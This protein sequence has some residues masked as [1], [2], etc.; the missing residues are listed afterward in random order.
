MKLK[1]DNNYFIILFF[2]LYF[3]TGI[4][5]VGDYSVT[6]D[7][8]LHRINGF[9]SLKYVADFLGL[10][11]DLSNYINNTPNLHED[12][13]KT[14]GVLFDLPLAYLEVFFE[15]SN[16]KDVFLIRHLFTFLIFFIANI[17]FYFLIH[18]N[19][20]NKV[21]A[22]TGVLILITTP[23]IFSHSFYNSKDIIFLSL[24]IIA[25]FYSSNILKNFNYKNLFLSCLF[26]AFATNIRIIGMY[27][28]LLVIFFY[29]FKN[30]ENHE[31]K[32]SYF[33]ILY[34]SIYFIILYLIWPF[35]WDN[36]I[37]NFF[38]VFSESMN[39]PAWW[40]FKTFYLG[41]YLNP[42]NL[43]WHYFFVWFGVTTP[44]I[45]LLLILLGVT[46]FIKE[47]FSYFIKVKLDSDIA[48]WKNDKQMMDLFFFL[49]LF[50]PL[51]FVI[52]LNSTMYNGWR[53]LY[54]LYPSCIVL[55]LIFL[56]NFK[57]K[58]YFYYYKIF[59]LII[60]VQCFSNIY[61]IYKS[62][63]V[64]NIYFNSLFKNYVKDKLPV[65]YWGVGNKK[66]VD[67]LLSNEKKVKIAVASYSN[68]F[69][70]G[71]FTSNIKNPYNK[72]LTIFGTSKDSKNMS[73]FI[74]TNYYYDRNPMNE[75]SYKIP[76]EFHS[77]YKLIIDGILVNEV[78]K[79]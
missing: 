31:I 3:A 67:Y 46:H 63:P 11:M 79:K 61:F 26:C 17:Y 74:L 60:L 49:I 9:I 59:L 29:Y 39:Y 1:F 36:P 62:H 41:Q 27:L 23:R 45:F 4:L 42:E 21:L 20:K 64:Q 70:I 50:T 47:Y 69:N 12:W 66:S 30:R 71:L 40:D 7:E 15:L 14:Y 78:F 76:K 24:M 58:K 19:L 38:L 6:P 55:G 16:K 51:F 8:P 22:F 77:Y 57:E 44:P 34:A 52:C 25:M 32:T 35:L 37:K 33:F 68:L 5:V 72:N 53:H 54:F 56:N 65:D 2:F 43:P 75:E 48:L 73:D 18:N 13:R 10:N 28:P